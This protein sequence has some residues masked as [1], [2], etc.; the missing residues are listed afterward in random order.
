MVNLV[1]IL[2][3]IIGLVIALVGLFPL[4]GWLNWLVI[5]IGLLGMAFGLVAKHK[6]GLYLNIMV[7]CVAIFRLYLGS[8]II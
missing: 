4:L 2:F 7:M 6:G 5:L 1:S 3:G 8:G